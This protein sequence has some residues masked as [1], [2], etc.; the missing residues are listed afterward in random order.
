MPDDTGDD[1]GV[2]DEGEDL[3]GGRPA[4]LLAGGDYSLRV[5]LKHGGRL[6]SLVHAPSGEQTHYVARVGPVIRDV[7]AGGSWN[8]LIEGRGISTASAWC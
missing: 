6:D 8:A 3:A 7:R 1:S 5:V 4:V 2:D